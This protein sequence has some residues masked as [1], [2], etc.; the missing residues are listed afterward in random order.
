MLLGQRAAL[1][2][3]EARIDQK[4]EVGV[5]EEEFVAL[6][7]V[8]V[9]VVG[10]VRSKVVVVPVAVAALDAEMEDDLLGRTPWIRPGSVREIGCQVVAR[11]SPTRASWR[12]RCSSRPQVNGG[13]SPIIRTRPTW[14]VV[15]GSLP[16]ACASSSR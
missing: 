14:S 1:Q 5:L 10:K 6:L 9:G 7:P 8:E 12:R 4:Q 15:S 16:R 2:S 11:S 13:R 3:V